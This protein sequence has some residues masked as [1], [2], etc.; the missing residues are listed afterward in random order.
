MIS[1]IICTHN[2]REDYLRQTLAAWR[3]QTL[4]TAQ[5]ELRLIDNASKRN[6]W[7]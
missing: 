5:G 1:V 6:L 2:P 4:P 3:A 7:V